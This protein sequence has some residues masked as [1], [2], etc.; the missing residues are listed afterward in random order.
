[1][2]TQEYKTYKI[3]I[4]NHKKH[5]HDTLQTIFK[6]IVNSNLKL[7]IITT[8]SSQEAKEILSNTNKIALTLI[9]TNME[10][11]KNSSTLIHY[12]R[13]ELN[14]QFVRIIMMGDELIGTDLIERYSINDCKN[15]EQFSLE[16][17][18]ATLRTSLLQY[19]YLIQINTKI[20]DSH[21]EATTDSLTHLYNRAKLYEDCNVDVDKTLILIDII[22]FSSIN[23]TYGQ[24]TG[25]MVLKEFA[26]FLYGMY[27]DDFNV[28]HLDNDLF[29]LISMSDTKNNIFDTVEHIKD[30]I[31]KLNIVTNNFNQTLNISIGVAHQSEKNILRKA[32]LALREARSLGVNKIKYYSTDL[33]VLKKLNN[34]NY[35][36]PIIKKEI[37]SSSIIVH[38]QPIYNLNT[39][40][41]DKYELLSRIEHEGKLHFPADFLDVV[42][43]THQSYDLFKFMFIKACEKAQKTDLKFSV[44][45][46]VA[47]LE[48]D[49]ILDFISTSIT[50]YNINPGLISIE[51]LEY[52]PISSNKDIKEKII[53]I[54]ELG[55]KIAID[56][57]GVNC[58]NF[59]QMQ[60][61]PIDILKIDGSFISNITESRNSQIVVKTIQTF[62]KEKNIKLTAEYIS[63]RDVLNS[64][65]VLGIEFGQGF[66]LC[67]PLTE[68]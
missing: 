1:M 36:G 68:I 30:D 35:W 66:Y 58:S 56:D 17:M 48:N 41:I 57:F 47:E 20:T 12:I 44:N 62:A 9:D 64:V 40:T 34:I 52:H 14:D 16:D 11:L 2:K 10:V 59:G 28:Y 42:Y 51:I 37:N 29:A 60:D 3:L 27:H 55:I 19:E 22:G 25:D 53:K 49:K 45:I 7:E 65:K 46:G 43:Q 8:Y 5:I 4:V 13:E 15:T 6:K 67:K 18:F 26:A 61:L 63:T 21:K 39:N 24:N 31:I 54:H 50:T 38:Y 23:E 32:E 33:K